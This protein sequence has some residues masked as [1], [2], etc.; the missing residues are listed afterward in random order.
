[1]NSKQQKEII[2]DS[3]TPPE[4]V[5]DVEDNLVFTEGEINN[6]KKQCTIDHFLGI[7]AIEDK[8]KYNPFHNLKHAN[9]VLENVRILIEYLDI[10]EEDKAILEIAASGHDLIFAPGEKNNEELA[11]SKVDIVLKQKDFTIGQRYKVARCIRATTFMKDNVQPESHLEDVMKIADLCVGLD[12]DENLW[13]HFLEDSVNI[14]QREHRQK[15]RNKH[16]RM[17]CSSI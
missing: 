7:Q 4:L 5:K 13:E 14:F 3:Y 9:N 1:M 8:S 17:V 16:Q 6:A 12:D 10:S 15:N 2:I 11:I